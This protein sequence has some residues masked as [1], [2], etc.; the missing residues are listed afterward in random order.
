MLFNWMVRI[1]A[2]TVAAV[3]LSIPF[4]LAFG[5]LGCDRSTANER[6][7]TANAQHSAQ[8]A[9]S[10]NAT[11]KN[12]PD[13]AASA[14][15]RLTAEPKQLP[16]L[17][18]ILLVVDAMRYDMPWDG[19]DRPI[20]PNLTKLREKSIA[21]E[22]GYALSSYTSKSIGGLLTGQYPSSLVRT[23]PFFTSYR[24][25]NVFIAEVLQEKGIRTLGA[26]AH[27]YLKSAAGF[28]QGFD[29]WEMVPGIDWDYNKDPYITS[30]KHTKL[31][32]EIHSKPENTSKQFFA[33]YHYMDPHDV[34]NRHEE[35]PLF[36][37]GKVSR[38]RY[39]QEIWFTD[40]YIQQMLD[41]VNEQPWGARTAIIVTGDHGEAF[42]ERNH[43]KHAFEL[44]EILIRVP[45]FIYVPGLEP[46]TIPRWRGH[47]DI[48]P[49]IYDLMGVPIPENLP[50]TS[51]LPEL[52]GQDI[53]QRPIIADLPADTYNVRKRSL[54][55]EQGYKLTAMG[56]DRKYEMFNVRTDPGESKNL[57]D[58]EKERASEMIERYKKISES[59][60]FKPAIGGPVKDY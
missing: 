55:D 42:G 6:S 28:H 18:V 31:I 38:D 58:V 39:D 54:I 26:Q 46:R 27:M 57:I 24:D 7:S 50:G 11:K 23:S 19:Y 34:Y 47:I 48:V 30:P 10:T 49:T 35:A 52:K 16:P 60:P 56:Q 13:P 59:I 5:T 45:L 37:T 41:Y 43:W 4:F 1:S 2:P 15:A 33:Y 3:L 20:A 36:G 12:A 25:D 14:T 9:P 32:N 17:N 8:S 29:V 40:K 22:R 53:P 44:Y 21:Y 51:L